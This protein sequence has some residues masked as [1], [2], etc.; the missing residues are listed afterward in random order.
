M[1]HDSW[2]IIK[3]GRKRG[4]TKGEKWMIRRKCLKQGESKEAT[5]FPVKK[6]GSLL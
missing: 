5:S 2:A 1:T 4:E 6:K 3:K